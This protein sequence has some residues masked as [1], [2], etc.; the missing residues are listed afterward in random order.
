MKKKYSTEYSTSAAELNNPEV[1][2][3]SSVENA[4]SSTELGWLSIEL[5][6]K[7]C[8]NSKSKTPATALRDHQIDA[9]SR[10]SKCTSRVQ[11]M[12][13]TQP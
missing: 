8:L 11:H 9:G 12:T 4:K 13:F 3:T 10:I 7:C 2:N 6:Q 5:V 1:R